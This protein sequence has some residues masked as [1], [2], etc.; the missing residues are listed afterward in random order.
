MNPVLVLVNGKSTAIG[1]PI[2]S[3]ITSLVIHIYASPIVDKSTSALIR[4]WLTKFK[5]NLNCEYIILNDVLIPTSEL[6]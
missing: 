6:T 2:P 3:T 1:D 4:N 5:S